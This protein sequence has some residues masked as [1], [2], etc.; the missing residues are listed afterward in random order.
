MSDK[1]T[2]EFMVAVVAQPMR[3]TDVHG[4]KRFRCKGINYM[5]N[6]CQSQQNDRDGSEDN[7]MPCTVTTAILWAICLKTVQ[8]NMRR[9]IS[10]SVSSPA[11]HY[12]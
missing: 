8:E 12:L 11:R 5:V 1:E 10:E 2:E 4:I 7:A 6:D 9:D 3:S